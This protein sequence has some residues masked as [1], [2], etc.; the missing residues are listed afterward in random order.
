M[1]SAIYDD[2]A[3]RHKPSSAN[4]T[5][6]RISCVFNYAVKHNIIN[7]NPCH[8]VEMKRVDKVTIDDDGN[9]VDA[10]FNIW[11][12]DEFNQF[13]SYYDGRTERHCKK[14]KAFFSLLY[15]T[16]IRVGE[17]SALKVSDVD[18][19]NQ[20]ITIN[21]SFDSI[22]QQVVTPKTNSSYRT[23]YLNA[24]ITEIL[25]EHINYIKKF[26]NYSDTCYL[27]SVRTPMYY[28]SINSQWNKVVKE[29]GVK[30]I[31]IHD[32]RHSRASY[33]I[34]AG[35]N[36]AYVS[37]QLGHSNITTTLNTYT[38]IMSNFE[39]MEIDKTKNER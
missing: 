39:Q 24:T 29:T 20:C 11:N 21:K 3:S 30:K 10:R 35:Y 4:D 14:Y 19:E 18:L 22:S 31:R 16:G 32:L 17:A 37:K 25:R 28:P 36:I 27:F 23:V 8:N 5:F 6:T 34:S 38:S 15:Y 13:I 9:V 1:L 7:K 26:K 2:I 12:Q 33:M